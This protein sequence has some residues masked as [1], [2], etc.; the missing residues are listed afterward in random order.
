MQRVHKI[1]HLLGLI[2]DEN[3]NLPHAAN[4]PPVQDTVVKVANSLNTVTST[5]LGGA[6]PFYLQAGILIEFRIS[7]L[8]MSNSEVS[9]TQCSKLYGQDTALYKLPL[10]CKLV[11]TILLWWE[12]ST[13]VGTMNFGGNNEIWWERLTWVNLIMCLRT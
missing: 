11:E 8:V 5:T 7:H 13:L 2:I 3:G 10:T 6:I 1:K 12:R 4:I 9:E